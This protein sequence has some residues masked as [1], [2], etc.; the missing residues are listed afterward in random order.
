M[1]SDMNISKGEGR[2]PL[3][4]GRLRPPCVPSRVP[5]RAKPPGRRGDDLGA[6]GPGAQRDS[7]NRPYPHRINAPQRPGRPCA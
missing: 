1:K 6:S 4:E 3:P 5:G 7:L 2:V